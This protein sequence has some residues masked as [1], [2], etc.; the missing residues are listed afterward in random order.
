MQKSR[1]KAALDNPGRQCLFTLARHVLVSGALLIILQLNSSGMNA[2]SREVSSDLLLRGV[3]SARLQMPPSRLLLHVAYRHVSFGASSSS[4]WVEFDG[5][6][7]RVHHSNHLG[8][9]RTI[10]NKDIV[11]RL[12]EEGNVTIRDLGRRGFSFFC[13]PR[14]LGITTTYLSK[15]TLESEL[16]YGTAVASEVVGIET[17]DEKVLWRVRTVDSH[18]Q[19][20]DIWIDPDND[21]RVYRSEFAIEGLKTNVTTSV[22][23]D[24]SIHRIP[25]RVVTR[26]YDFKGDLTAERSIEIVQAEMNLMYPEKTWGVGGLEAPV[27]APVT[28]LRIPDRVGYWDG[29]GIRPTSVVID[30]PSEERSRIPLLIL[31][32]FSALTT[33]A[34][35]F[36]VLRIRRTQ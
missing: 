13:D 18:K 33:A 10:L 12:D 36:L 28:D 16:A 14:L 35:V 17:N 23:H 5:D 19:R 15:E 2:V 6:Q 24:G 7:R 22:Y 32:S 29:K 1:H 3:E 4:I 34:V 8:Q 30:V 20:R 25:Y 26:S 21:F 11:Y 9:V 31:C 27:G